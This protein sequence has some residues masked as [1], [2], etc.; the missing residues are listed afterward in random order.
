MQEEFQIELYRPTHL[1]EA[2]TSSK[3]NELLHL[4]LNLALFIL[5]TKILEIV[6]HCVYSNMHDPNNTN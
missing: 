4:F 1:G 3:Y 2:K 5:N 6:F